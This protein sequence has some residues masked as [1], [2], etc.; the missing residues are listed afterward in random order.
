MSLLFDLKDTTHHD[1]TFTTDVCVI[2]AGAVGIYLT[3]R[4]IERGYS[5]I[6]VEAGEANASDCTG[7]GFEA[8]FTGDTYPGATVGRYFGMGGSTSHWGGLLVP[9]TT[10]DIKEDPVWQEIVRTVSDNTREVLSKLGYQSDPRFVD[11]VESIGSNHFDALKKIDVGT[12][13]SLFLPFA[14][15]NFYKHLNSNKLNETGSKIITNAV[16]SDWKITS[17]NGQLSISGITAVSRNKNRLRINSSKYIVAAGALESARTLLELTENIEPQKKARDLGNYLGDHLSLPIADINKRNQSTIIKHFA[18]HFS[19]RWMR[20]FRFSLK[21]GHVGVPRFFGHFI[22]DTDDSGINWIKEL[23]RSF[24]RGELPSM[25]VKNLISGTGS[26]LRLMHQRFAKSRLYIPNETDI[27]FQLDMEQLPSVDNRI[28]LSNAHDDYGRR[29]MNIHWKISQNDIEAIKKLSTHF[30]DLWNSCDLEAIKLKPRNLNLKENKPH[31][32]YHPVGVTKMGFEDS[33][34]DMSYRLR[35]FNNLFTI[36]TGLLPTAGT[37]NPTFS[38][39]CLAES[40][41]KNS[42][43]ERSYHGTP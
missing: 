32:A 42:F 23:L 41:I 35:N 4:L 25:N 29:K 38:I 9:H 26:V 12:I 8:Q 30:L 16:A 3:N 13:T 37:A 20:S 39:L 19:G 40:L 15:K 5:V 21:K 10:S 1:K 6:L 14:K 33:P 34:V 31:D 11:F 18:P 22:F 28:T 36:S 17:V 24:Q 7:I 43:E 2:G 27:R